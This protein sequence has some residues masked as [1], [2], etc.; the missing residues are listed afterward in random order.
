MK[1]LGGGGGPPRR[2]QT[3]YV[4]RKMHNLHFGRQVWILE[5]DKLLFS[6]GI[7]SWQ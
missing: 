1:L 3:K 4:N 2:H 5:I 6:S 7:E